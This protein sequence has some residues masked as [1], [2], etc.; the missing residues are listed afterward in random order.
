MA[1]SLASISTRANTAP[2]RILIYGTEGVGKSSFGASAPSPVFIP[3]EDGLSAIDVPSFPLC[4]TLGDVFEALRVLSEEEH[5]F[6]TVV[7]DSAD[8]TENLIM[9]Q[10]AADVGLDKF[11]TQVKGS[12]LAYGRGNRAIAEYWYQIVECLDYLRSEKGMQVIIVAHCKVQRFDDPTTDAYDRYAIDLAKE[13]ASVLSEWCDILAFATYKVSVKEETV[14]VNGKK[15]RGL[16]NGQRLMWTQETPAFKAK[17]RWAIP[18]QL[19][20]DYDALATAVKAA[21]G[22]K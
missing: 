17:S 9:Q 7:L 22:G 14:G 5:E 8:W 11:D 6:K 12:P 15:R 1:F 16:G 3:T 20:L 18:D 13:S 4:K 10:V 2:P 21:Q 19:P